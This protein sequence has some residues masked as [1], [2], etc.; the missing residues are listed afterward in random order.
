MPIIQPQVP[1][2]EQQAAPGGALWRT[3]WMHAAAQ[4]V[5]AS[6]LA[7]RYPVISVGAGIGVCDPHDRHRAVL[8]H[9]A[10]QTRACGELALTALGIGTQ[11]LPRAGRSYIAYLNNVT[12]IFTTIATAVL[13]HVAPSHASPC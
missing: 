12:D 1:T 3:L 10:A 2:D 11:A 13:A 7:A 5:Y 4:A 8:L 9:P 6:P